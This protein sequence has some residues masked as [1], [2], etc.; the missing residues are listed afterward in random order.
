MAAH[1]VFEYH[2]GTLRQCA[3]GLWALLTGLGLFQLL[4]LTGLGLAC[5]YVTAG[6][7]EN[8]RGRTLIL[9]ANHAAELALQS[10]LMIPSESADDLDALTSRRPAIL[11]LRA[12]GKPLL[13]PILSCWI[14]PWCVGVPNAQ[15]IMQWVFVDEVSAQDFA[16]IRRNALLRGYRLE[17]S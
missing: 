5:C 8:W 4:G 3:I 2:P 12:T 6:L 11:T 9:V 16:L 1:Q 14:C 13:G 7:R 10:F 17:P 15:G